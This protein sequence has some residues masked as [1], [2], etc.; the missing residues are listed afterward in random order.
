VLKSKGGTELAYFAMAVAAALAFT[1][2][3]VFMK[4]SHGFSQPLPSLVMIVLFMLGAILLTLSIEARG[5]LGPAYLVVVGLEAIMAFAFGAMLF[6][7]QPNAGRLVGLVLLVIGMILIEG[8]AT[9]GRPEADHREPV[10]AVART[11]A[12]RA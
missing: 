4:L 7:E 10:T 9:T 11:Q 8:G 5:E 6:G 2:G 3:G 12:S 1:I